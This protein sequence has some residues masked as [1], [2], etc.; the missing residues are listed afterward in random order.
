MIPRPPRSTL[1]PYTTRFRSPRFGARV[2][3]G[4]RPP[5]RAGADLRA[6]R[7]RLALIR[8]LRERRFPSLGSASRRQGGVQLGVPCL[9]IAPLR[10]PAGAAETNPRVP[11]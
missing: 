8:C 11:L 2:T 7:S 4:G 5:V 6:Q 1:F 3:A 10:D 9:P